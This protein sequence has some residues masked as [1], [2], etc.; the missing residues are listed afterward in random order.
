M[1]KPR[2]NRPSSEGLTDAIKSLQHLLEDVGTSQDTPILKPGSDMFEE[3]GEFE[4]TGIQPA[5]TDD[6]ETPIDIDSHFNM[7]IPPALPD[8]GQEEI[9]IPTLSES[10]VEGDI[11]VLMEA[12]KLPDGKIIDAALRQD[13]WGKSTEE[14]SPVM[15]D[16]T[17]AARDAIK[18]ILKRHHCEPLSQDASEVL[19][20]QILQFL[21][22]ENRK[23]AE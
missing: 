6:N 3:T 1:K 4:M 7:F 11:P 21:E 8:D 16:A 20:Q 23:A 22:N 2:K 15:R 13:N 12:V 14:L 9:D 19:E 10:I 17:E 5:F 18:I